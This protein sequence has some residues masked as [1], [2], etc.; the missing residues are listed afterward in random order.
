M[1]ARSLFQ[2]TN[3]LFILPTKL[4]FGYVGIGIITLLSAITYGANVVHLFAFMLFGI[5]FVTM[6]LSFRNLNGLRFKLGNAKDVFCGEVLD[7]KLTIVNPSQQARHDLTF[8]KSDQLLKP[9]SIKNIVLESSCSIASGA[10]EQE[11]NISIPS[12]KRGRYRIETLTIKS[13]FPL[14]LFQVWYNVSTEASAIV[15][16]KPKGSFSLPRFDISTPSTDAT[17]PISKEGEDDFGGLRPYRE[18]DKLHSIVWKLFSKV[19]DPLVK[20][21]QNNADPKLKFDWE[22]LNLIRDEENRLSQI[23]LW[24]ELAHNERKPFS[25]KMPNVELE[26]SSEKQHVKEALRSLALYPEKA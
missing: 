25:L 17:I 3:R 19:E 21:L 4:G 22:Q 10:D 8:S 12:I 15:Y 16:P 2:K 5:F 6:L 20:I 7:F 26:M 18:G 11:T 23:A 13:T 24:I 9:W 1:P 14:G